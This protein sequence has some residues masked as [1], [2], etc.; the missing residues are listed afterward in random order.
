M[1]FIATRFSAYTAFNKYNEQRAEQSVAP[2]S[3]G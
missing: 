3:G 2:A 1:Q